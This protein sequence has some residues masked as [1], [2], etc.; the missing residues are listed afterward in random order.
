MGAIIS[1]FETG[2]MRYNKKQLYD[3]FRNSLVSLPYIEKDKSLLEN[4]DFFARFLAIYII[5]MK[6]VKI[7]KSVNYDETHKLVTRKL[8]EKRIQDKK[9]RRILEHED[10]F[11]NLT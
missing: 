8:R 10:H 5:R 6:D 3:R 7:A 4:L 2:T 1:T 11:K 9:T